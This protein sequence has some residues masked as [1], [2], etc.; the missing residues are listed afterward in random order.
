MQS[1]DDWEL[2]RA[3][4]DPA[5]ANVMRDWLPPSD[6]ELEYLATGRLPGADGGV[7]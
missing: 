7:T 3:F 4:D 6:E 5:S 2:F 1:D